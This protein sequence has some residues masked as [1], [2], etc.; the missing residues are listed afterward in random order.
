MQTNYEWKIG[1]KNMNNN[2]H[3]IC[4]YMAMYPPVIPNHFIR[5]F[6]NKNSVILDPFCGRGTTLLEACLLKR[7]KVIGN[8][9]NPLAVVLSKSKVSVPQ[10]SR[11]ISRLK[12]LEENCDSQKIVINDVDENIRM[13]YSD[14][15]LKQIIYLKK[16]LKW[17]TSIIDNFITT[18]TLGIMHGKTRGYLSISMPNTFSMSP[19]YIKNYIRKNSLQKPE[20]NTFDL[21][22]EKLERCYQ[23]CK[24]R[25]KVYM[26]DVRN[27]SRIKNSSV[28]LI[29]T[30]PPYTRLITYGKFNWIR[31]WFLGKDGKDVDEKLFRTQSLDKYC[32][33]MSDVLMEF[34][35]VLKPGGKA[36]LVIG[37]VKSRDSNEI[38]NLAENV[39]ERCA[40]PIGFKK[41]E[42]IQEDFVGSLKN[43]NPRVSRIWGEKK[44]N[45]TN[46]ER[47][48]VIEN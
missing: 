43:K 23:P 42:E 45:A 14:Y 10:K 29:M 6:S 36:V 9:R 31:L 26:Q 33:F 40:K 37:D 18:M 13:L 30:S 15:T 32:D 4:S 35:R 46:V 3:S 22:M 16:E 28:D 25:G 19:N 41:F 17:K 27:M 38:I 39:W 1:P 34:R 5:K 11:I 12:Y 20:R 2:L 8:D 48:L 21:L 24:K 7:R 44:G 47:F